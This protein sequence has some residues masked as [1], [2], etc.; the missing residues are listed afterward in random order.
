MHFEGAK[1][2]IKFALGENPT[3][4][5]GGGRNRNRYP[6]TRMGVEMI[7]RDRFTQAKEYAAGQEDRAISPGRAK[8]GGT[9]M[10]TVSD[11]TQS[12][13]SAATSNSKPSPRSSR[14]SGSSTATP[15]ARTRS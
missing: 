7:I 5:N 8:G 11:R 4:M 10:P 13:D 15:T 12:P 14:E 1:P 9:S 2:G 3:Q 6:I